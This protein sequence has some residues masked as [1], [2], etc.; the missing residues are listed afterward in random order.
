MNES[1]KIYKD[2]ILR[3]FQE[4][5]I[6]Y[7]RWLDIQPL[8]LRYRGRCLKLRPETYEQFK[9]LCLFES[10]RR[11]KYD[12]KGVLKTGETAGWNKSE[13]EKEQ[14]RN[15]CGTYYT[16]QRTRMNYKLSYQAPPKKEDFK[17]PMEWRRAYHDWSYLKDELAD[18]AAVKAILNKPTSKGKPDR[19]PNENSDRDRYHYMFEFPWLIKF[20]LRCLGGLYPIECFPESLSD[21]REELQKLLDKQRESYNKEPLNFPWSTNLSI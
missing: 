13:E 5:G 8:Y 6:T 1:N 4:E 11:C 20:A 18:Y 17:F 21:Y 14:K 16:G 7:D 2:F 12:E 3:Y 19:I 9:N 15:Y 10:N